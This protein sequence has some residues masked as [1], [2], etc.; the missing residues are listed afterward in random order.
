[1]YK[2]K[3]KTDGSIGLYLRGIVNDVRII[4][5]RQNENIYIPG[6]TH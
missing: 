4:I 3:A 5:Q 6:L 2:N 1:M